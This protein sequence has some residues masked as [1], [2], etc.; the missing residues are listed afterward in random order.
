MVHQVSVV[1]G[2]DDDDSLRHI[3]SSLLGDNNMGPILS[4]FIYSYLG[5]F[6]VF[7]F[8]L[9]FT[10]YKKEQ[11]R[12]IT[13]LFLKFLWRCGISYVFIFV[14][15]AWGFDLASNSLYNNLP[16]KLQNENAKGVHENLGF[17]ADLHADTLMWKYRGG[18]CSSK[19]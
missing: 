5:F 8:M 14:F 11:S 9:L 2:T 17:I 3:D 19:R 6:I 12:M 15:T 10:A 7:P 18:L 4:L 16:N 1:F 13:K